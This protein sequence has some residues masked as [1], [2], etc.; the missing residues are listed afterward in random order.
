MADIN[1]NKNLKEILVV[2]DSLENLELLVRILSDN[3]Y[4]VRPASTGN[5]ALRSI[6]EKKPD[7]ILLDVKLPDI[8]GYEVCRRIRTNKQFLNIPIIF[9]SALGETTKKIEGFTAGG[10]DYITKPFEA[11]EVLARIKTHLRL[12]ALTYKLE[13]KVHERTQELEIRTAEMERFVYSVSHDLKAP[14]VTIEGFLSYLKQ[15]MGV[16][17]NKII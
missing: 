7:L 16:L 15:E 12:E 3:G 14:L 13:Q 2:D 4:R 1:S 8:D 6:N 11:K 9:I 5:L 17:R 10:V